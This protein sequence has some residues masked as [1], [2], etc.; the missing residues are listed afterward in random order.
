[1]H[2]NRGDKLDAPPFQ[3]QRE[4]EEKRIERQEAED[5]RREQQRSRRA[6]K[7]YWDRRGGFDE[8]F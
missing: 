3:P 6:A 5:R 2:I 7:A 4:D 1:M 8:C